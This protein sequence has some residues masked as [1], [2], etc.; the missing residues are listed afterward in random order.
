MPAPTL[1]LNMIVRNEAPII[2]RFLEF[3]RPIIDAWA[4]MDTG[5]TDGTPDIIATELADVPGRLGSMEWEGFA[6][7][8][9]A[10]ISLA[11]GLG[12]YLLFMDAD[13]QAFLTDDSQSIKS[14]LTADLH[15]GMLQ[16]GDTSYNRLLF[17]KNGCKA[18][19]RGVIHEVLIGGQGDRVGPTVAGFYVKRG[20]IGTGNRSTLG[21]EK[22]R[23][24]AMLL[25]E[26][27]ARNDEPDFL[28][29]YQF[30]LAQS[31]RDCGERQRALEAYRIR[32]DMPGGYQ[33][34][35]YVAAMNIG[36]LLE[37]LNQPMSE[38][39]LSYF[40]AHELDSS[41]AEAHQ[42]IA[43]CARRLEMWNLAFDHAV[44]A[45]DATPTRDKLFA[46]T[47]VPEWKAHF[48]VS[49]AA[50]HV[51]R[52]EDGLEACRHVL[53]SPHPPTDIRELTALH[54]Q[55]YAKAGASS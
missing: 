40:R 14:Q 21:D 1:V 9:N 32:V 43:A 11:E 16:S 48:E 20:G 41:R 39:L 50:W 4:I 5:S 35:R 23:H 28:E 47:S 31:Y 26:A 6:K 24:D 8:R 29:R 2:A 54:L 13:D 15:H 37:E 38:I 33:Q 22:Y 7:S 53:R 51:G 52:M 27:I 46:D 25:E 18:R 10:A 34:E 45:R 49:V 42:H 36:R 17:A 3:V 44:K 12:D 19:Y 30:Y 55:R